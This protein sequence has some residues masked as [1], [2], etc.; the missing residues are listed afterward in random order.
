MKTVRL[1]ETVCKMYLSWNFLMYGMFNRGL[2]Q[3]VFE[4]KKFD[5]WLYRTEIL[6][7]LN[8][9]ILIWI[10]KVFLAWISSFF[11]WISK[12]FLDIPLLD[13]FW[14]PF[15]SPLDSLWMPFGSLIGQRSKEG[16]NPCYKDFLNP[17]KDAKIQAKKDLKSMQRRQLKSKEDFPT[18]IWIFVDDWQQNTNSFVLRKKLFSQ[19][20][21]GPQ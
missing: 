1:I 16:W 11:A 19:L 12:V 20:S 5:F 10:S 8:F 15:R 18:V 13:P 17:N 7:C 9:S 4:F 6:L 21:F 14:I 2:L 3:Y